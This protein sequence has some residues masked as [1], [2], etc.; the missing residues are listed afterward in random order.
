MGLCYVMLW[1][2]GSMADI[3]NLQALQSPDDVKQKIQET[4]NNTHTNRQWLTN[5]SVHNA[6]TDLIQH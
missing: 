2:M 6:K 1:D 4:L 5:N 3:C